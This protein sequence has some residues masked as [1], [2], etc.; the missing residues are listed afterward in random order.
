LVGDQ[1]LVAKLKVVG[2]V[3]VFL[4]YAVKVEL[5][6]AGTNPQ[7]MVFNALVHALSA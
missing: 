1:E 3:P 5:A 6:P 7:L 2:V 4:M